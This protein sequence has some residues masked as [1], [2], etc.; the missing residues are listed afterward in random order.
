MCISVPIHIHTVSAG[1][2][3]GP[4]SQL[5]HMEEAWARLWRQWEE[6]E[7]AL[8]ELEEVIEAE[9]KQEEE[10]ERLVEERR[11]V[12]EEQQRKVEDVTATTSLYSH[13]VLSKV[14]C[15]QEA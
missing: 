1:L 13:S 14:I 8:K 15:R 3:Q 5:A 2:S 12:E 7:Q 4:T 6:E 9:R 11:W 10:E